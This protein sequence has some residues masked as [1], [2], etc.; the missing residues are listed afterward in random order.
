MI[1]NRPKKSMCLPPSKFKQRSF[2]KP[3]V[4]GMAGTVIVEGQ[5]WCFQVKTKNNV[6]YWHC[7]LRVQGWALIPFTSSGTLR[8][9]TISASICLLSQVGANN[10]LLAWRS[11]GRPDDSAP[12]CNSQYHFCNMRACLHLERQSRS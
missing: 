9:H 1:V 12:S 8:S 4:H 7:W 3:F 5:K 6:R 10:A 2:P 11:R